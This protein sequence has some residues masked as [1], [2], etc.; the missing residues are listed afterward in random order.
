MR[1]FFAALTGFVG[2]LTSDR[3]ERY[4]ALAGVDSAEVSTETGQTTMVH[5]DSEGQTPLDMM[6]TCETT[7]GGVLFDAPDGTLTLQNRAHRYLSTSIYTLTM[8]DHEVEA[9]Y[10]PRLDRTGL[11]NDVSAQNQ[12]NTVTARDFDQASIDDNGKATGSV[13]TASED[14]DAPLFLASW[15]VY[16]F[17]D[18]K[19]RAPQLAVNATVQVGK[20]PNC[21]AVMATA[22]GDKITVAGRPAQASSSSVDYFIE[23]WTEVYG[24][25]SLVITFNVTPSSPYDQVLKIG[26]STRG[27]IGTNPVAF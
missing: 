1:R 19:E 7:E 12:N 18:P 25:E 8:T 17:K 6:R 4:A 13:T 14:D 2:D 15:L 21:S 9:G 22:V 24:P 3:F 16:Q 10:S 20:T 11:L 23:G 26:D 27:V 5:V